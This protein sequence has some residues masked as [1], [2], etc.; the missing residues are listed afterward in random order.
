MNSKNQDVLFKAVNTAHELAELCLNLLEKKKYDKALEILN[1]KER[2]V[3][4]ILHLDEQY[5]I[6][7]DNNQLNKLFSEITKMDQEIFN[8]LTHEKLLTQNEIAKTRKNKENFK[9]YNLNDLK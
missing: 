4:I 3:N 5:G 1:N 8:L 6:P 7:K 9:G 2:V